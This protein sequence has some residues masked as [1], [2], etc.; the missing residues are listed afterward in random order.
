MNGARLITRLPSGDVEVV[1]A[2][3]FLVENDFD[4]ARLTPEAIAEGIREIDRSMACDGFFVSCTNIRLFDAVD[5]LEAE[6][7]RPVISSNLA[8]GWHLLRLAGIDDPIAGF[9][10]LLRL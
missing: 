10:S 4:V 1:G 7:G 2:G 8:L 5:A 6:F 3:S 9:G